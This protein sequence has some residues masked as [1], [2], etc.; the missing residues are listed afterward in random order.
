MAVYREHRPG[1]ERINVG[2]I[3]IGLS[4]ALRFFKSS[5]MDG[6]FQLKWDRKTIE[7]AI[8]KKVALKSLLLCNALF[9]PRRNNSWK[10][11]NKETLGRS[12]LLKRQSVGATTQK[13][14]CVN[15]TTRTWI[16]YYI[17]FRLTATILVMLRRYF[18][19][20]RLLKY[21]N[22]ILYLLCRNSDIQEITIYL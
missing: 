16:H 22:S 4:S 10:D 21:Q 9:P 6:I 2:H 17:L 18:S 3:L 13:R 11:A 8:W 15:N 12:S 1:N 14:K 20:E 5:N 19:F 7:R